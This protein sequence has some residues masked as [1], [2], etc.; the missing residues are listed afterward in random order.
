MLCSASARS[1]AGRT[2]ARERLE[3]QPHRRRR[4]GDRVPHHKRRVPGRRAHRLD[5]CVRRV[6][7][8]HQL[9]SRPV[10]RRLPLPLPLLPLF[11]AFCTLLD[12]KRRAVRQRCSR[13]RAAACSGRAATRRTAARAASTPSRS[14][15][16][17]APCCPTRWRPRRFCTCTVRPQQPSCAIL[18]CTLIQSRAVAVQCSAV[19]LE[20]TAVLCAVLRR[21][22]DGAAVARPERRRAE[23]RQDVPRDVHRVGVPARQP[24]VGVSCPAFLRVPPLSSTRRVYSTLSPSLDSTRHGIALFSSLL[25]CSLVAALFKAHRQL[26][27]RVES[28]RV[29]FDERERERAENRAE[30]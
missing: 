7:R 6:R 2:A 16:N 19:A 21:P 26:F 22:A 20:V 15:R 28:R 9:S 4:D 10:R 13:W 14:T 23:R 3:R 27:L 24:H 30:R 5:R 25:I 17:C 8:R 1:G 18:F 12:T 29:T 11:S